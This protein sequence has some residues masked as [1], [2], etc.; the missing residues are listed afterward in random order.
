MQSIGFMLHPKK[1]AAHEMELVREKV[2]FERNLLL[3][4]PQNFL[5]ERVQEVAWRRGLANSL[6]CT[7]ENESKVSSDEL[8]D[9]YARTLTHQG[10]SAVATG[11]G[12]D[13]F[14]R[15]L[16]KIF[17]NLHYAK[18]GT[19]PFPDPKY[20][21]GEARFEAKG[22]T[23]YSTIAF[24]L[25]TGFADLNGFV[26]AK[27][28]E[29]LF[30]PQRSVQYGNTSSLLTKEKQFEGIKSFTGSTQLYSNAGVLVF[31]LESSNS[32][33]IKESLNR[34]KSAASLQFSEEDLTK[35]K[36]SVLFEFRENFESRLGFLKA[37]SEQIAGNGRV[38]ESTQAQQALKSITAEKVKQSVTQVFSSKPSLV[39]FGNLR[40]LPY[41]DEL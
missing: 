20:Y 29:K 37:A 1:L 27:I 12:H 32:K 39:H 2:R 36:S 3:S 21:G 26:M 11:V 19:M 25:Q 38:F 33:S 15:C 4:N 14:A 41:V 34:L 16:P 10:T 35:A 24:P 22:D 31:E 17:E 8:F 13:V 23:N 5:L 18:F 7:E 30:V 28:V 6:I 40:E 9:F